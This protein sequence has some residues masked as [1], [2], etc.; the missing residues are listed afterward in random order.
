MYFI[1]NGKW[2]CIFS[3]RVGLMGCTW[4]DGLLPKMLWILFSN[5]VE[6]VLYKRLIV[7]KL[8]RVRNKD[9][10]VGC[11]SRVLKICPILKRRKCF[12]RL[13]LSSFI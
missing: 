12:I 8:H 6:R 4:V 9:E 1:Q 2:V 7:E 10:K 13:G 5:A 3:A 11:H